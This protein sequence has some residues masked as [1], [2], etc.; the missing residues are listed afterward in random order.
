MKMNRFLK[1]GVRNARRQFLTSAAGGVGGLALASLLQKDGLLAA[2]KIAPK[3]KRCIFFF[4]EGGP[5]QLDLF[6]YKPKLNELDGQRPPEALVKDKR[7]A[8]IQKDT[9]RLMGTPRTFKQYGKSGIWLSD[10]LPELSRHADRMCMLQSVRTSQFNHHPGQLVM[11]T[12]HNLAGHPSMGAWLTYGLGS[13]NDNLPGYVVMNSG[14]GLQGGST[15]WSSGFLSSQYAA[16]LLNSSSNPIL[17]LAR[18]NGI[19][20]NVERGVVDT[21]SKLMGMRKEVTRDP[22]IDARIAGY[23]LAFRMQTAAPE[24]TDLSSETPAT[25][26]RYGVDRGDPDTVITADKAPPKPA[27]RNFATHCLLAR[28][29]VEKGVRFVNVFTGSWDAHENLNRDLPWYTGMV[30]RPIAALVDD[31]AERGLLDET[32]VVFA[33]EFGR[34]PLGENAPYYPAVTGRD[35]HPDAFSI[36]MIG[37]GVKAGHVFGATDDIGWTA[38]ENPVDVG[39]VH[40][41]ILRLFGIDHLDLTYRHDGADQRLTPLTQQSAVIEDILA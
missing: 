41:T 31:L 34:T 3:A 24:V 9:A 4:M 14:A 16:A 20:K 5:S 19:D 28:R 39:D 6:S 38:V 33:G 10:L 40:A 18:P 2:T 26:A 36:F 13:E 12:G 8:F 15:L 35:H 11:Q 32:L 37:G 22:A 29:M 1:E 25:L 17:N 23:E 30:D 7:F 27:Y 21:L